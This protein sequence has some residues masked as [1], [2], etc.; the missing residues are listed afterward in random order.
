MA[1]ESGNSRGVEKE[2]DMEI[3]L[4]KMS[5]EKEDGDHE[6]VKYENIGDTGG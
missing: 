5:N 3:I 2:E 4:T 1:R 6:R